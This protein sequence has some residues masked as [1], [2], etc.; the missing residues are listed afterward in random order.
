M[1][2]STQLINTRTFSSFANKCSMIFA[3]NFGF[4]KI[5]SIINSTIPN[6]KTTKKKSIN[7]VVLEREALAGRGWQM[8]DATATTRGGDRFTS[9]ESH[10]I[11]IPSRGWSSE[12]ASSCEAPHMRAC[13]QPASQLWRGSR[14]A[15]RPPLPAGQS[16]S[17]VATL[18]RA[19]AAAAEAVR[20]AHGHVSVLVSLP[21]TIG[22]HPPTDP[23]ADLRP[24]W[25]TARSEGCLSVIWVEVDRFVV[26]GCWITFALGPENKVRFC[27]PGL[28]TD[29][30]VAGSMAF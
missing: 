5:R 8:D 7:L 27:G 9:Y 6:P 4:R 10:P 21:A 16:P 12:C 13:C 17:Q 14:R 15:R 25:A 19:A 24:P 28:T 20:P 1:A 29:I 18:V 2:R 23:C 3:A 11:P 22:S 26:L 30:I